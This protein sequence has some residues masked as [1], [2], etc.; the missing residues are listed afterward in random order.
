MGADV[1]KV[2]PPE[3]DTAREVGPHV[4]DR[5]LYYS[6][7]NTNKRG[8]VL[9]LKTP[10]GR[11]GLEALVDTADIVVENYRPSAIV[12]LGLSP[13]ELIERH[14]RL[15]I[16]TISSY[17]R[18]TDRADEGSFDLVAQAES[19]IMSVTGE[20]GGSPVRAGVA[21][22]DLAAG[23]WGALGAV[24]AYSLVLRE[25]QGRHVEVPLLDSALSLLSYVA[26]AAMA[27]GVEPGPVGSGHHSIVPY[28][29]YPT[30]DGWVVVAVLGDK[31][32][33]PLCD[34]IGLEDLKI[35][36]DLRSNARRAAAR[37]EVDE[38]IATAL[39]H[40]DTEEALDRLAAAGIPHGRLNTILEALATPYVTSRGLVAQ[41]DSPEGTYGLVRG[42]LWD[43]STSR[44]APSLGEHTLEVMREVLGPDSPD[45]LR[46][47]SG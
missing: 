38:A 36:S 2:E 18:A 11:R 4:D 47:V 41:L 33:A 28:R 42:P 12:K 19:G 20:D 35:R 32:W 8:V 45:L 39:S 17:A 25:G 46:L 10:E 31:F 23:L 16:L 37:D 34:A 22:A 43:R 21:I 15:V 27:T 29:A 9:D 44:P 7:L 6:A 26:T 5:S 13:P 40:L 1:I 30:N 24:A 3:G 14:P